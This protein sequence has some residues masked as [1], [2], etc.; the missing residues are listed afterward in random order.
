MKSI[1]SRVGVGKTRLFAID[2]FA[3]SFSVVVTAI[4]GLYEAMYAS[5]GGLMG[6]ITKLAG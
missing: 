3:L 2:W 4:C 1:S 6:L 5:D